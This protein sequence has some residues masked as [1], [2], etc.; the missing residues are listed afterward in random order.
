[1]RLH[2]AEQWYGIAGRG[3]TGTGAGERLFNVSINGTQ[4]LSNFDVYA[5]A[6]GP[7]IADVEQ[8]STLANSSGDIVIPFAPASGSPDQNAICNGIEIDPT[9]Q[10]PIAQIDA[11]GSAQAP[12]VTDEG[13]SGGSTYS[14]SDTINTSAVNSA[15]AAVYDSGREG[16]SFS[17]EATG[18]TPGS[19]H[20]VRL[21]FAELY[22]GVSGRGGTSTGVGSRFFNVSINGLQMLTDYDV[23]AAAG[24]PDIAV[25]DQL[26][27]IA[28]SSGDI[29][30]SFAGASGSPDQDAI[31]SGIELY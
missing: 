31:V 15:P 13:Y 16:S 5:T 11:G 26:P 1:V 17:Y 29:T 21:H 22:Y 14:Y 18:L 23:Y 4:V 2:F 19:P 3:G 20:I 8:F 28:N 9:P 30:I 24:G 12:F 27:A 25:V 6:G 7:D 10:T